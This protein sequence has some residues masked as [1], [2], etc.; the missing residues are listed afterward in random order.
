MIFDFVRFN[1]FALDLL[2]N[3][4]DLRNE[5]LTIGEY[6]ERQGYSNSFRSSLKL[7]A[8]W[9]QLVTNTTPTWKWVL[10]LLI[11]GVGHGLLTSSLI[12]IPQVMAKQSDAG[13][14]ATMYVFLRTLGLTFGI[15]VGGIVFQNRLKHALTNSGLDPQI[16][17]DAES[18]AQV[19]HT[20]RDTVLKSKIVGAYQG[21][22]HIVFLTA[23]ILGATTLVVSLLVRDG[24]INQELETE[25]IIMNQRRSSS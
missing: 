15:A 3:A 17:V 10:I 11:I 2:R 1:H 22:F 18:F 16:A 6:L 7:F 14:A 9:V 24:D 12:F 5:T 21:S 19:L 8:N 23:A 4:D 20:L 25:H 13:Y